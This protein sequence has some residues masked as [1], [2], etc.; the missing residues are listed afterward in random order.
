MCDIAD[1]QQCQQNLYSS[2][3]QKK[4]IAIKTS[5]SN[6]SPLHVKGHAFCPWGKEMFD[7]G[8]H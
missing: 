6:A 7:D 2:F 3:L 5:L 1:K 4:L 8:Y